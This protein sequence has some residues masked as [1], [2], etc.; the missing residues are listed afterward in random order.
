MPN[1]WSSSQSRENRLQSIE[2]G[3]KTSEENSRRQSK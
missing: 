2:E 3:K 1:Q